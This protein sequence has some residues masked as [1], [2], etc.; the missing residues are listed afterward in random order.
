MKARWHWVVTA[1]AAGSISPACHGGDAA[2]PA[3]SS[4]VVTTA[5]VPAGSRATAAASATATAAAAK[6]LKSYGPKSIEAGETPDGETWVPAFKVQAFEGAAPASLADSHAACRS[7]TMAL[8][9]DSQWQRACSADAALAELE[10]WT[11]SPI[12]ASG[13]VVRGGDGKCET[14]SEGTGEASPGRAG[15]CCERVVATS[16][17]NKH[18]AFRNTTSGKLLDYEKAINSLSA[19]ALRP[20]L[21][22]SIEYNES[23]HER[24]AYLK[25]AEGYFRGHPKHWILFDVCETS[26]QQAEDTWT[27]DCWSIKQVASQIIAIKERYVWGGVSGT[28]QSVTELRSRGLAAAPTRAAIATPKPKLPKPTKKMDP[29]VCQETCVR[30]CRGEYRHCDTDP[31]RKCFNECALKLCGVDISGL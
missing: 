29:F 2:P 13:F 19:S 1:C 12:G 4:G 26:V 6:P 16:G 24:N 8:C 10:T 7:K 5:A 11:I 25:R 22:E 18:P 21:S 15:V 14:R 27:A 17:T 31:W 28:L 3:G 9:T 23:R 30:V 20:L